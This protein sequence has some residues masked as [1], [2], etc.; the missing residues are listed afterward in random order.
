METFRTSTMWRTPP[1]KSGKADL[2]HR[3]LLG[4]GTTQDVHVLRFGNHLA[5]HG[6]PPTSTMSRLSVRD[7]DVAG[8]ASFYEA[9]GA[10]LDMFVSHLFQFDGR[11]GHGATDCL[12]PE[13][14]PRLAE[15]VI[16]C[17]RPL[18]PDDV[19]VGQYQGYRAIDSVPDDSRTETF[20][21]A[22]V[23]VDNDRWKGVPFLLRTGKCLTESHQRVSV[24]FKDPVPGL[25]GQPTGASV[26][27]LSFPATGRSP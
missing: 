11:S 24:A 13:F 5:G 18:T 19:V 27:A 7:L 14:W 6:M 22:K 4:E 1:L 16:G 23:W 26:S 12:E 21:A 17:F 2:R 25:A 20:V 8:Q 3:S 10:I 9:T 15:K